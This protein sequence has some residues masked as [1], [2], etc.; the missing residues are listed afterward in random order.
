MGSA[1]DAA[2]LAAFTSPTG[3]HAGAGTSE[4]APIGAAITLIAAG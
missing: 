1:T 2:R 4:G 3:R